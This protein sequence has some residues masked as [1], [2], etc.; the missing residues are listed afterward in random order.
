[1]ERH[2][3]T[4]PPLRLRKKGR[5]WLIA[6]ARGE[7]LIKKQGEALNICVSR[8]NYDG[9]W[10]MVYGERSDVLVTSW[11]LQGLSIAYDVSLQMVWFK[12][13]AK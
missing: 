11:V 12:T 8:I 6:D 7:Y 4:R 13:D 2:S 1:M 3:L 10:S 9:G 5:R